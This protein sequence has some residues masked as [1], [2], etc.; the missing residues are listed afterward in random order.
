MEITWLLVDQAGD[1][2]VGGGADS[3]LRVRRSVDGYLLDWDDMTFKA[4]GWTTPATLFIEIDA[5]NLPGYY[6]KIID[7]SGWDDGLYQLMAAYVAGEVV[8]RGHSDLQVQSG[9]EIPA[10]LGEQVDGNLNQVLQV[11]SNRLVIDAGTGAYT[12]YADDGVTP[13][14]T[15]TISNT[16]RSVPTWP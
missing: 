6:H 7:I 5:V 4:S 10:Y 1:P 12:I 15:G 2:I 16:G 3:S 9:Q 11:L 8:A 13:L 14:L